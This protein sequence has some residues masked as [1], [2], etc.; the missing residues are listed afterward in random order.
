MKKSL[1]ALAALAAIAGTAS[2]QTNLTIY[3]LID[4]GIDHQSGGSTGS[5]NKLSSGM[6][7]GSRLGFK[8]TED[9]GGGMSALFQL[10]N[11][12]ATDTG[13]ALQGGA[14]FGRQAF[15][16]L[17]GD[18]GAVTLGRQYTAIYATLCGEIDPFACG[19][20][21]TAGNL[22]STGG[23]GGSGN[24]A[25][26]NNSVKYAS[27]VINGFNADVT[28]GFGEQAGN[29]SGGRTIGGQVGYANGPLTVRLA[30][31]GV[32]NALATSSSKV[33][34]LGGKY[35]FGPA[36]VHL[37]YAVNKNAETGNTRSDL[38]ADGTA[39]FPDARVLQADTRDLM[40]GVSVPCGANTFLASYIKKTDKTAAANDAHQIALGY[41]YALSKRTNLYTSYARISNT[42]ANNAAA[43]FY[44]VGNGTEGGTGNSAFNVGVRHT[45]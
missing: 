27:P 3:G 31:T 10:E 36:T 1:L 9:L 22:M 25:R 28:Y 29:T 24:T 4:A 5:V 11:G 20:A 7:N 14:L 40:V 2:A 34:L 23:T 16:G 19:M 43:G 38:R 30:H 26:T 33:T 15:V 21:G 12:F 17:K 39:L 41:T 42:V 32:N 45:F 8:G 6:Q 37:A 35:N 18:T 13:A 44:T